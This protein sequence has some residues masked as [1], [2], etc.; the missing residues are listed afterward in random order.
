MSKGGK[1]VPQDDD[2]VSAHDQ[3]AMPVMNKEFWDERYRSAPA[4]WSGNPNPH[5]VAEAASLAAGSALEV[6]CGEGA[7]AIWLAQLGWT[8]TAVDISSVA[9]ERAHAHADAL[10]PE[11]GARI[12][13][14]QTD[15]T[16]WT[17]P[18][19]SFDLVS[20][21]F[22]HLP[23]AL[24]IPIYQGLADAVAPGG[25]L[26][27]VAHHPSDME[28]T[29]PRP[30]VPDWFFTADELADELD[31]GWSI[32][33]LDARPRSAVDPA[34]EQVTIHDTVLIARRTR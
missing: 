27:I 9:L 3:H 19:S 1:H 32:L 6:G 25:M 10:H 31:G 24:R 26:L 13:W 11:I 14:R 7:D 30:P 8:V 12:T 22:M 28:T 23:S 17:P 5:L 20:V 29:I 21:Q 33:A 2:P 15:L 16:D 34:G 4:L 18:P